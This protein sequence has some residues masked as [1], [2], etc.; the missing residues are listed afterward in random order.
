MFLNKLNPIHKRG[1]RERERD[2]KN[3]KLV[4]PESQYVCENLF[5]TQ[6]D[7]P[8]PLFLVGKLH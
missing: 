8:P 7:N 6:N 3:S 1:E 4:Q 2:E 5:A